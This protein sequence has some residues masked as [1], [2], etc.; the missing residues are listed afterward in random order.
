M[1]TDSAISTCFK[2][3]VITGFAGNALNLFNVIKLTY[4]EVKTKVKTNLLRSSC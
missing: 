2:N 1:K 4:Q 3:N